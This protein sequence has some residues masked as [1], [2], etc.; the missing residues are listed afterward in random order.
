MNYKTNNNKIELENLKIP[1]GLDKNKIMKK[2]IDVLSP[3]KSIKLLNE[4]YDK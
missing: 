1:L 2:E 3:L 4:F